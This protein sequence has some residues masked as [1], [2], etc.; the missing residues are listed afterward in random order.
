MEKKI[1]FIHD[2]FNIRG[3]G[4]GL[5]LALA[6]KLNTIVYSSFKSKYFDENHNIKASKLNWKILTLKRVYAVF[7]YLFIFKLKTKENVIFSGSY[8]LLSLT[9]VKAN[10]KIIYLHSLPKFFL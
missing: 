1:I 10:K 9:K 6:K 5:I 7:Y 4:E 2:F 8:S 3:G